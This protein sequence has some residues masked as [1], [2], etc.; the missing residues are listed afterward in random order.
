[1]RKTLETLYVVSI[2]VFLLVRCIKRLALFF[3]CYIFTIFNDVDVKTSASQ[4]IPP[5]LNNINT[6]FPKKKLFNNKNNFLLQNLEK[7]S[8]RVITGV[9]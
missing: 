7:R 3:V 2:I 9:L 5:S 4:L 8:N 1:M 6:K